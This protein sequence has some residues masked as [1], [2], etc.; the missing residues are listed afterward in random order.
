MI[1]IFTIFGIMTMNKG[2]YDPGLTPDRGFP[3]GQHF[4]IKNFILIESLLF[5]FFSGLYI[6]PI[7]YYSDKHIFVILNNIFKR[8]EKRGSVV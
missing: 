4:Y 2:V 7:I 5:H 3:R 6:T 8:L 1:W